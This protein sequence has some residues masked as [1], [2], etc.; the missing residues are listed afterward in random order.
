ML[1]CF[2]QSYARF[3]S[4]S[5]CQVVKKTCLHLRGGIERRCWLWKQANITALR[6]THNLSI[7]LASSVARLLDAP[8]PQP[9]YIQFINII[10][11]SSLMNT[12]K[13]IIKQILNWWFSRSL[14]FGPDMMSLVLPFTTTG[15]DNLWLKHIFHWNYSVD[16]LLMLRDASHWLQFVY[17]AAIF[18]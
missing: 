15:T 16:S 17:H 3:S 10:S 13:N 1:K 2:Y 14:A 11:Y 6:W 4:P 18:Q 9:N 7:M 12:N 5:N 8:K